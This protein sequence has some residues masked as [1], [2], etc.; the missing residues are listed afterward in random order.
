MPIVASIRKS[1]LFEYKM[2][3]RDDFY[4]F[5]FEKQ[6]DMPRKIAVKEYHQDQTVLFPESIT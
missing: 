2:F 5:V 6:T 4:I 3:Y 1:I